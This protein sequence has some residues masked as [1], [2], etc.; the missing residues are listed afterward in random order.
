MGGGGLGELS[1]SVKSKTFMTKT[2]FQIMLK[3]V[4]KIC[5][6]HLLMLKLIHLTI[7]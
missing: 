6:K 2:F 7:F 1:E 4:L 5:E 3:E